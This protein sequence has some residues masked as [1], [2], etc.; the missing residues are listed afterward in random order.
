MSH[1]GEA[2][3]QLRLDKGLSRDDVY[4]KLKIPI[5]VVAAIETNDIARIPALP[6][7]T[8]FVKTYC[9]FLG[10]SPEPYIDHVHAALR[11]KNHVLGMPGRQ[12]KKPPWL[13]E[14]TMWAGILGILLL[15]WLTYS[16]VFQP[17]SGPQQSDVQAGTLDER[18]FER[19][20]VDGRP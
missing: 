6:Y 13:N 11:P 15:C 9:D 10:V 1:P 16:I 12:T 20:R 2:L 18:S 5:D 8:G 7:T 14:A 4:R 17:K 19:S 3:Q